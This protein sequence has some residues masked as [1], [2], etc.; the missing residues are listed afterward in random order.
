MQLLSSEPPWNYDL[1]LFSSFSEVSTTLV[2][3]IALNRTRLCVAHLSLSSRK[4]YHFNI[5][6]SIAIHFFFYVLLTVTSA[7]DLFFPSC[8]L[9]L[10]SPDLKTCHHSAPLFRS[11]W[12]SQ[13]RPFSGTSCSPRSSMEKTPH[14][15][16]RSS[17][18]WRL[19][20]G[21]STWRTWLR[22]LLAQL[23][24]TLLWN[25]AS[26]FSEPRR[27]RRWN[28]GRMHICGAWGPSPGGS[29]PGTLDNRW[30]W[31][32]CSAYPMSLLC[33]SRR[34]Q[35]TWSSTALVVT[36][37]DGPRGLWALR[38]SMSAGSVSC[39]P[40]TTTAERTSGRWCKD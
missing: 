25:S 4:P 31:T 19:A 33:S 26:S 3:N 5:H 24:L 32:A 6:C 22:T 23:L 30:T 18:P 16:R 38:S 9:A 21:R 15:S 12:L 29:V 34:N 39:C 7:R 10:P 11:L 17:E 28:P 1:Q 37:L 8:F 20:R 40:H 13:S 2:N 27:K 35:K 36:S 14:T